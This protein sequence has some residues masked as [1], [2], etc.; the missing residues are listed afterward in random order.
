MRLYKGLS[1]Q[2]SSK[3]SYP[4]PLRENLLGISYTQKFSDMSS[5][6]IIASP[7]LVSMV[8]ASQILLGRARQ[9]RL[10]IAFLLGLACVGSS[11]LGWTGSTG[12]YSSFTVPFYRLL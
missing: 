8:L 12:Y 3:S 1:K 7:F 2:S 6:G 9:L 5:V 10:V 4:C 11:V